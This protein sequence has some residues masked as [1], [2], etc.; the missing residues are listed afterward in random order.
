[1]A[2][3]RS[4]SSLRRNFLI[5]L[6]CLPSLG[7]AGCMDPGVI[8]KTIESSE[9]EVEKAFEEVTPTNVSPGTL[10]IDNRPWYGSKAIPLQNGDPLPSILT[11]DDGIV[12]TFE[13]PVS[14]AE[15][16]RMIQSSTG[17]RVLV[18]ESSRVLPDAEAFLPVDGTE[19][20]GGRIVWQGSLND[21]LNQIIDF[22]DAEWE[23]IEDVL[24]IHQEVTKTFMLHALA[25]EIDFT[26]DIA[27]EGDDTG[28]VPQ[29][30]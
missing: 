29:V 15:I 12:M 24:Y 9:K 19:V 11:G 17:M 10:V 2:L 16:G 22:F 27:N 28:V 3:T 8:N 20:A 26:G 25:D 13:R 23:Y 21:F 1:M 4:F 30:S 7:V 6:V 18:N 5:Y 14:L